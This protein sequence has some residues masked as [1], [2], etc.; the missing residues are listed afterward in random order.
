M[1]ETFFNI[2]LK[3]WHF[4][5]HLVSIH[6]GIIHSIIILIILMQLW[7]AANTIFAFVR[8]HINHSDDIITACQPQCHGRLVAKHSLVLK[9]KC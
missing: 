3:H 4:P 7:I 1:Y 6:H 5:N 2:N 8:V 9:E